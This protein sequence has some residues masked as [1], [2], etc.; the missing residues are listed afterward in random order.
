MVGVPQLI[1][2]PISSLRFAACVL[3][4]YSCADIILQT[5]YLFLLTD[6]YVNPNYR[7]KLNLMAES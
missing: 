3:F 1:V 4:V 7:N 6:V 2:L 5:E